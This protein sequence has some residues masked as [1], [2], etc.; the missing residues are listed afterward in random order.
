MQATHS[1]HHSIYDGMEY[2]AILAKLP[3]MLLDIKGIG[4]ISQSH[5]KSHSPMWAEY[6]N[7]EYITIRFQ[8][9]GAGRTL[10]VLTYFEYLVLMDSSRYVYSLTPPKGTSPNVWAPSMSTSSF[11]CHTFAQLNM[12]LMTSVPTSSFSHI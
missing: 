7:Y 6:D 3:P 4:C 8:Q 5:T 12:R 10:T 11:G 1:H 2:R 9:Y